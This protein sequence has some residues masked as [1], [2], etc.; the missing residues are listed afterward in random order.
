MTAWHYSRKTSPREVF[1]PCWN[2]ERCVERGED[3]IWYYCH[4]ALSIFA[5]NLIYNITVFHLNY[6][7]HAVI[8]GGDQ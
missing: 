7:F 2:V 1:I 3:R 5:I 8:L 6:P 4:C